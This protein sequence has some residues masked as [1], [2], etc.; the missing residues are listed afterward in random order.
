MRFVAPAAPATSRHPRTSKKASSTP[1]DAIVQDFLHAA[2]FASS[3]RPARLAAPE[4]A[5]T[6]TVS[7]SMN[8][9]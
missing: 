7:T 9:R 6:S 1:V 4:K 5:P 8:P 3:L 2:A